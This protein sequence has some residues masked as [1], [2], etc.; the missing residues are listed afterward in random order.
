MNNV[1]RKAIGVLKSTGARGVPWIIRNAHEFD[2]LRRNGLAIIFQYH[3]L[4][5]PTT[6][7]AESVKKHM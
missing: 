4:M 3:E 1:H 7:Y 5:V 6:A 2:G